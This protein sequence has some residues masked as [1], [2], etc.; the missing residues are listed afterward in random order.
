MFLNK[1]GAEILNLNKLIQFLIE[2]VVF[3]VGGFDRSRSGV[4]KL[5]NCMREDACW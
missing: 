4:R 3:G 2:L 5:H 1:R